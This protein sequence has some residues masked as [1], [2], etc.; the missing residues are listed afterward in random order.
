[1]PG[2]GVPAPM[3]SPTLVWASSVT[4]RPE[5]LGSLITGLVAVTV[6]SAPGVSEKASSRSVH[7]APSVRLVF[8]VSLAW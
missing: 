3:V 6:F 2:V 5:T 8:S 1:M 7:T 4:L